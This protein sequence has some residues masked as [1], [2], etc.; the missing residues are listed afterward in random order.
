MRADYEQLHEDI[1][2]TPNAAFNED[3]EKEVEP[4]RQPAQMVPQRD[5]YRVDPMNRRVC[6]TA[7]TATAKNTAT[8][9]PRHA[10]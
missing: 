1:R 9:H 8:R 6:T 3:E 7:P 5:Y 10:E 2:Y 4:R